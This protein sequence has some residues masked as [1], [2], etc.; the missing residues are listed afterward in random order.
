MSI[1]QRRPF[2]NSLENQSAKS[3]PSLDQ[4]KRR[5][6]LE[7]EK[8]QRRLGIVANGGTGEFGWTSQ[9]LEVLGARSFAK[10]RAVASPG[11]VLWFN[12]ELAKALRFRVPVDGRMTPELHADLLRALSLR[13]VQPGERMNGQKPVVMYA[14]RY[15]GEGVHPKLGAARAGFLAHGN[16]YVKGVGFTPLFR[17][18]GPDD[19][20]HSHGGVQLEDCIAEALFGEINQNLF[21]LGSTRVLAI[22]DQDRYVT[23]PSGRKLPVALV[24]RTGAQL[25][26]AHLLGD[27]AARTGSALRKF[28]R[29]TRATGQLLTLSETP[30]RT[31]A[32]DV[33]ATMLRI[34]DHQ[35]R[36]AAEGFR[37]RMLHGAISSSNMEMSG[38]MLDV[39]TQS[40]Q[41][42]TAP[43]WLL[44][45]VD[46]AFGTEHLERAAELIPVYRRI[47]RSTPRITRKQLN[48]KWLAIANE[49]EK[50]YRRHL[51]EV[52]LCA[53]G[54]KRAL[55]RR[56]QAEH[57]GLAARFTDLIAEI[58]ALRNP[59]VV[60]IARSVVENISVVDVFNLLR[61]LPSRYFCDPDA[62]HTGSILDHLEPMFR[63]NAFHIARRRATVERTSREFGS[64]YRELM[65]VCAEY[66]EEFYGDLNSM[67][68]SIV[69]RAEFENEPLDGLYY[70]TLQSGLKKAVANYKSTG[71]EEMIREIIDETV[72]SSVRSV[73]GL[74]TQG[75]SRRLPRGG[76]ELQIRNIRGVVY[77]VRAWNDEQQR[78]R[79][80]VS[81][82]VL[83]DGR[84]YSAAVPGWPGFTSDQIQSL[85]CS[86]TTDGWKR[87][88]DVGVRLKRN[89]YYGS[90]IDFEEI[91]GVPPVGRIEGRLVNIAE[92]ATPNNRAAVELRGY[93]FAIPDRYDLRELMS[94][95]AEQ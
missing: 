50:A 87:S 74:L 73:E 9:A 45:Y 65:G 81:I 5:Q 70:F 49:M 83:R 47:L 22:I 90:V 8:L 80:H 41:P 59:G 27:R 23:A 54:L 21:T 25:R 30:E 43:I 18:G 57:P 63:G 16:L 86:F 78:R 37:W 24:V 6:E 48:V 82:P 31:P 26:P 60:C 19:F 68:A 51:Q 3:W 29:I 4:W 2:P 76:I 64:L 75:Y 88:V 58:A 32:P 77:S 36:T 14:D 56:V 33:R 13:A 17:E 7:K 69:S 15:G 84:T 39:P 10:F 62:D 34:I 11:K 94:D 72:L 55:A 44:D 95:R 53:A 28:I 1:R 46:S 85:R 35:A 92:G 89:P 42:R 67:Q 20:V 38:A 93:T 61:R 66:A 12:F 40:S 91:C 79:L 52:L 71:N